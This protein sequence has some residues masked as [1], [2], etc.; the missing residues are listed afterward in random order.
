M[1]ANKFFSVI[2]AG[3]I[4]TLYACGGSKDNPQEKAD[5][6]SSINIKGDEI[7]KNNCQACHQVN[8]EGIS[9]TFPPLAKSDFLSNKEQVIAQVINGR[10]GEITVN[11]IKY[12]NV[13][14]PQPLS[15][16]EI[17]AVLNYVYNNF[18]NTGEEDISVD[19]V[20]AVRE[21]TR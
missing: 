11:G 8:G 13:M 10:K 21:K 1:K 12:N 14:P 16:S 5:D 19:E 6:L 4:I 9:N 17:A 15:D 2:A 18:G 7:Y 20:K 3:A